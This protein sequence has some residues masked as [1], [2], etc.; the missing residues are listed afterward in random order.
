MHHGRRIDQE[1]VGAAA[2][3]QR[4]RARA[5]AEPV[6]A[7]VARRHRDDV[8][9][10]GAENGG[11]AG[12]NHRLSGRDIGQCAVL[13]RIGVRGGIFGNKGRGL[14]RAAFRQRLDDDTAGHGGGDVADAV[15]LEVDRGSLAGG[16]IALGEGRAVGHRA[17][18]DALALVAAAGK[19]DRCDSQRRQADDLAG[20]ADAVVV[21]VIPHHDLVPVRDTGRGI[22]RRRAG[23]EHRIGLAGGGIGL[24]QARER[25]EPVGVFSRRRAGVEE[26]R[27]GLGDV[28]DRRHR[29]LGLEHQ[30]RGA[31]LHPGCLVL[32][33]IRRRGRIAVRVRHDVGV[34]IDRA[35]DPVG[36]VDAG[37]GEIKQQRVGVARR[38]IG[39]HVGAD[40][41]VDRNLRAGR[42]RRRTGR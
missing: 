17:A 7:G 38:R 21:G 28:G 40:Q 18:V 26:F 30:H 42:E 14:G 10:A 33:A 39:E 20:I 9:L 36:D 2:A 24:D 12:G 11:D 13:H 15:V 41:I 4:I 3:G 29:A 19:A 5:A 34:E 1:H 31:A 22:G 27:D 25:R 35:L 8:V 6:G 32:H 16:A 37:A 23:A